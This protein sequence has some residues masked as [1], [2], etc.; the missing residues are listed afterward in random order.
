ML[1]SRKQRVS[2]ATAASTSVAKPGTMTSPPLPSLT[3]ILALQDES[4]RSLPMPL[5]ALQ[6]TEIP[7]SRYCMHAVDVSLWQQCMEYHT[8]CIFADLP[9]SRG[10]HESDTIA[11]QGLS[12]KPCQA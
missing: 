2:R 9:D 11:N 10:M 3:C 8:T 4:C 5:H 6:I 1:T 7:I 12:Q